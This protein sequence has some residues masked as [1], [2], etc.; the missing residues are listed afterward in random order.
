MND[1]IDFLALAR[2]V[3]TYLQTPGAVALISICL[4]AWA[5]S[6]VVEA[7]T[8]PKRKEGDRGR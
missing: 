1:P 7:A 4:F 2:G 6:R 8:D 3:V 5:L